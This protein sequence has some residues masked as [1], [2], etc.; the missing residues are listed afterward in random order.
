MSNNKSHN[1]KT[2]ISIIFLM[3]A[4]LTIGRVQ[5]YA[6]DY[7]EITSVELTGRGL[8]FTWTPVEGAVRYEFLYKTLNGEYRTDGFTK[9]NFRYYYNSTPAELYFAVKAVDSSNMQIGA[10]D[11]V[12]YYYRILDSVEIEQCIDDGNGILIRWKTVEGAT[13]YQIY[14]NIADGEFEPYTTVSANKTLFTDGGVKEGKRYGYEI[15][16]LCGNNGS[17][18]WASADYSEFTKTTQAQYTVTYDQKEARKQLKMVNKFRTGK[19]AWAYNYKNKKD[20]AS[21]KNL[22]KLKWDYKLEK[23]A[24]QRAAEIAYMFEHERPNGKICFTAGDEVGHSDYSGE[25]IAYASWRI[26]SDYLISMWKET[27]C[28]YAGQGHRRNMLNSGHTGFASAIVR[29]GGYTFGVQEFSRAESFGDKTKANNK[30]K[31]AKVN[32]RFIYAST[33]KR[34]IPGTQVTFK[35]A[36]PGEAKVTSASFDGSNLILN[37]NRA[38]L[39]EGYYIYISTS[40]NGKYIKKKT[41]KDGD[42]VSASISGY[43]QGETVFIKVVPYRKDYNRKKISPKNSSIFKYTIG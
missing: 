8:K 24:M 39:A 42:V 16:A 13:S 40:K 20:Y 12:G 41:V 5:V 1:L 37:W 27:N 31:T 9:D 2:V 33:R 17:S 21:Y 23:A 38:S 35:T 43:K 34:T 26:G 30:T 36:L 7:P 11:E 25:N 10:I 32:T 19:E 29:V 22:R 6:A 4:L 15:V 28:K 14:R 3:F 18:V